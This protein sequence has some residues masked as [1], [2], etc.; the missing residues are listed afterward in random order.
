MTA[1][2]VPVSNVTVVF[3]EKSFTT[4]TNG[5]LTLE[6]PLVSQTAIYYLS[7][8][9][10]GYRTGSASL[11]VLNQ[12]SDNPPEDQGTT[13]G[14]ICG[15]VTTVTS[16]PI[17]AAEVC[18]ILSNSNN[19]II[20]QCTLSNHTGYY[21][22]SVAPGTYAMKASKIGYLTATVP[23]VIVQKNVQ[24]TVN[25]TLENITELMGEQYLIDYAMKK[26]V[27]Q[28]WISGAIS[29][30]YPEEQQQILTEVSLYKTPVSVMINTATAEQLVFSVN[31]S[32]AVHRAIL[33]VRFGPGTLEDMNNV[34]ILY[35]NESIS[36]VS[37]DEIFHSDNTTTARWSSVLAIDGEGQEILYCIISAPLSTHTI[38]ISSLQHIVEEVG[39]LMVILFYLGIAV[40]AAVAFI[41]FGEISKRL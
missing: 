23:S 24:T 8:S 33:T 22:I 6:A 18:I 31:G 3:N 41:G 17:D 34:T 9:K 11:S 20:N 29:V 32:E 36:W 4:D 38:T 1:D 2:G 25:F 37:F 12:P 35:D 19:E 16:Q 39:G 30:Q 15:Y 28:G 27:E 10:E 7:A 14:T 5:Y 26:I 13:E 40:V 21:N